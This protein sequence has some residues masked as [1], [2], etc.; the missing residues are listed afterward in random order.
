MNFKSKRTGKQM[1]IKVG[2]KYN[3][4]DGGVETIVSNNGYSLHPVNGSSGECYTADGRCW[5]TGEDPSDLIS[6]YVEPG[7]CPTC[8]AGA[9]ISP[10]PEC[11]N[12]KPAVEYGPWTIWNGGECPLGKDEQAQIQL[13]IETRDDVIEGGA[14]YLVRLPDW[15]EYPNIIAYRVVEPDVVK[16]ILSS[17]FISVQVSLTKTRIAR[18][19]AFA[20]SIK[21]EWAE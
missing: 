2:K 10:C 8:K 14:G 18:I 1:E 11:S 6:E 7:I 17:T 15:E 19:T 9:R 20:D 21:A 12:A 13:A 4:R 16:R 3:R 5:R